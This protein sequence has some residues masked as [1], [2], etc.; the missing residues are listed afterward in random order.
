MQAARARLTLGQAR[1]MGGD[2]EGALQMFEVAAD[3]LREIGADRQAAAAWR[4]LAEVLVK[5]G[6]ADAALDAYRHAADAAGVS[7]PLAKP[8]PSDA[9]ARRP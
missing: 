9:T 7:V 1:L 8:A 5:L 3:D 2:N 4:E 6:R